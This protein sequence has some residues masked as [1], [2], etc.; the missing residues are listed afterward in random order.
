[1][2]VQS[3]VA[4][5]VLLGVC[6]ASA[7]QSLTTVR[8]ASGL[9]R[10]VFV[11]SPPGDTARLFIVEQ[12]QSGG[13]QTQAQI[14]ILNLADNTVNATPFLTIGGLATDTEQGLLG[15]AFD[16][17]Y[18]TNGRFFV[19]YVAS[20][21]L[22]VVARYTVSANP[23]VANPTGTTILTQSQPLGNHNGGWVAFGP[24]GFL[25]V[26]L[27]DGGMDDGNGQ[28]LTTL[29]GKILRLDVSGS[30]YTIPP[31]NP[32]VNSPPARGEIW[33]FGLRNPW[34]PSFDRQTGD[35]WIAD[36]GENAWEEINVQPAIGAPPYA[37][38][39]YG[40]RCYEGN[41]SHSTTAYTGGPQCSTVQSLVF[42]IHTYDHSQ[43]CSITGGYVYRGCM[44]P[45]LR[46][47]YFF[48]DYCSNQIFSFQY[49]GALVQ[50]FTNRTAEL[51]VPGFT[52][53]QIVSFGEDARGEMY[54]CDQGGGE[55]YKIVPR[56]WPNCDGSTLAPVLTANDF[57]CYLDAFVSQ[58][59]YANCDASTL[60]P[61]L[62]ANDFQCFINKFAAGCT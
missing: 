29:L 4:A 22:G 62:T 18:A 32:F 6:G 49:A 57:Q 7:G 43:G 15:L 25:Y 40:W 38:R 13:I 1:M 55:I 42:P 33:A 2:R 48:A 31:T 60:A 35:L 11:T 3:E 56:C 50:H 46:G 51:A 45:G 44:M 20:G 41:E 39:N 5:A 58:S 27:G 9:T 28:L 54:I 21:M 52:I 10:P 17:N 53:N 19:K 23:N 26:S 36:V 30:S 12:R 34:R 61:V 14:K 59:C 16:P 37:A 47:T 8:V 24:D